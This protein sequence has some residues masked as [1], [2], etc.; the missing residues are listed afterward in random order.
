MPIQTCLGVFER[1]GRIYA[2]FGNTQVERF[3]DI[4]AEFQEAVLGGE[5][6]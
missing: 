2:A 3:E 4:T 6:A 5:P 1:G